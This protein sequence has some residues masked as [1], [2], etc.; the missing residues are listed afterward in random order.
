MTMRRKF[1]LWAGRVRLGRTLALVLAVAA[2]L[3]AAATY[4][5][6]KGLPPFDTRPHLDAL[7]LLLNLVLVLP[8][9]AAVAWRLVQVW[10]ERRRGLAGSRLHVR[11]VLVFSLL[12]VIPT[13]IVAVFSYLLF[14]FGV[15]A[16]FSE[17]V[18]TALSESLVVAEAYLHEHQQ[19]IRADVMGMASDLNRDAPILSI[20]PAR[21]K[22]IVEAQAALRSLSE[23]LVFDA[24][25]RILARTGLSF[26]LQLQPVP[27]WAL[28]Q[29]RAGDV[30]ILTSDNDDRVRALVRLDRFGDVFL[31]VGRFVDPMVIGHMQ[32]TQRAVTQYEQLEGERSTYQ[33]AF[34][35]LFL[36]V[37][38]LLLT[39]A[40]WV[41]LSFATRMAR[42]ISHLIAAAERVRAGNLGARVPVGHGDEEFASLS[43]AFNRMTHQL[44]TQRGELVEA[45]RQ[46]DQ[47]RRFT[48]TVL[49][50]VSAG[51]IGLDLEGR[52]NLPNRSAS[53]LL[54][55][56]LDQLF[57][58]P[59]AEAVPEMA[60]LIAEAAR[61]PDRL[62]QSEVRIVRGGRTCTL[63]VRIAAE[64]A[65]GE[66]KG[67]VVTFDDVTELLSAQRKAAWADVARRIAH[68]I[69]NP[70][71]PIQLSAERLKRKYLKEI[72]NDPE[73]FTTCTDT[74]IR[75]VGD[76]GRMVDEFSSFARM[77]APVFRNVDLLELLRQAAFLQ[78]TATPDIEVALDLPPAPLRLACDS[79]QVSQAIVNLLKNAAESIQAREGEVPP[80]RI[81]L[82]G[83]SDGEQI[84]LAVE[85]NGRGLPQDGRDRLTEP[86]VTTRTKGT[87]LGLAIVKK[88][89]EDH[90]GELVLE[91]REGGGARVS[92]VFKENELRPDASSGEDAT[93]KAASYGA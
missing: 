24:D 49:A 55:T 17:R 53:V 21:L 91:D 43:R 16:W 58:E 82:R 62:A 81:V 79:R 85:D 6:L 71:T 5:A 10:A 26:A 34:S 25:G 69:K 93:V 38:V 47:R 92:L 13:I 86:Y 31:Y 54:G 77:P 4:A 83:R 89:M 88:I 44:E 48:E 3:S 65:D 52:I 32:Q 57:G 80:G 28:Q 41:G 22:Q 50:G 56:D 37:G 45:N 42:P 63:L 40:V 9:F 90:K 36:A 20:N 46:L 1:M 67:F 64:R 8:L 7:F 70:L 73:T 72:G 59:L 35:M 61:R 12:A 84:V 19:A 39:G 68:E 23:A 51:V 29:A 33:I 74:I 27:D 75:H 18:R 76:I 87:G 78:R 15:Q 14:S 30:A 66:A 11:F 2:A 60:P